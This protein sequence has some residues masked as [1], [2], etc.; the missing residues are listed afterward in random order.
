MKNSNDNKK[1]LIILDYDGTITHKDV[2]FL[3]SLQDF[4]KGLDTQYTDIDMDFAVCSGRPI[5][6][7][8]FIADGFGGKVKY[9]A[10]ETGGAVGK[11]D[12]EKG[13]FTEYDTLPPENEVNTIQKLKQYIF[14]KTKD[15]ELRLELGKEVSFTVKYG[16]GEKLNPTEED[17][18]QLKE[19]VDRLI[20]QAKTEGIVT[21]KDVA[22]ITC[23]LMHDSYDVCSS[24]N[25]AD[26]IT[27]IIEASKEEKE[28][29]M[30][31]Y[32]GDSVND[33]SAVELVLS[34]EFRKKYGVKTRAICPENATSDM[35]NLVKMKYKDPEAIL[36]IGKGKALYGIGDALNK[37]VYGDEIRRIPG[38]VSQKRSI[39][40]KD[41]R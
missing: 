39:Q 13:F 33:I 20:E 16:N 30:V 10:C 11:Y 23:N 25:K 34:E 5:G 4:L 12:F 38:L 17:M 35:R 2:N 29:D 24:I 40:G 7:L 37:A 22:K 15:S 14:K 36:I 26:A 1:T 31:I 27:K 18:K 41:E 9:V 28:Y 6:Y 19:N 21:D 3:Q 8:Q 32:G